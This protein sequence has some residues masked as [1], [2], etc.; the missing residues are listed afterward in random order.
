MLKLFLQLKNII[1]SILNIIGKLKLISVSLIFMFF[2]L[3][4]MFSFM[5]CSSSQDV[6]ETNNP[7][8]EKKYISKGMFMGILLFIVGTYIRLKFGGDDGSSNT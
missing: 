1:L 2:S 8:K 3:D 4:D 7:S 6:N 5:D